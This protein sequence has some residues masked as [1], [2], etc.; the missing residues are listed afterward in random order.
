MTELYILPFDHRGSFMKIIGASS[1]PT[2]EDI[3]KAREYKKIIYEAFKKSVA[4]GVPKDK[5]G[6]LV[7]EWLGAEVLSDAKTA[8]FITCT[9]FEK[10]GQDEFDFDFPNYKEKVAQLDPTYVKVLVRYNPDGDK[11]MNTHQA[12]RLAELSKYLETQKNQFLFELLVP[13]TDAQMEQAGGDKDKYEQ[14]LRPELMVR[15]IQELQAAGVNPQIWKLEGLDTTEKMQM[16]GD[17]VKAGNPEASIIILGRGESAEKAEH[18]LKMGAKVD[19]AIGFAVGRTVFKDALSEYAA[20]KISRE[21]AI[22][23]ISQNYS[24]FV[25]TWQKVKAELT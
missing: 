1:P 5:A 10:S 9:P 21:Q 20:G 12:A 14:E 2:D 11:D 25:S 8:G 24:F 17:Q 13:A 19:N 18:W 4:G 7:D 23:K 6:I 3:A 15:A 16:V 22:E